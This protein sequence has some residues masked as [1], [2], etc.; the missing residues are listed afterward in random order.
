MR[1][2]AEVVTHPVGAA[3]M[4]LVCTPPLPPP[5]PIMPLQVG[6]GKAR[7]AARVVAW[8]RAEVD[9]GGALRDREIALSSRAWASTAKSVKRRSR[10]VGQRQCP[11]GPTGYAELEGKSSKQIGLRGEG[12]GGVG[13]GRR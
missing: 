12:R 4:V 6:Q 11:Q 13:G 7:E 10:Q 1:T 3:P 8:A 2:R 9:G 5:P